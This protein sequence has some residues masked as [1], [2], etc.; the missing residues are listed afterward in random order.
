MSLTTFAA[1]LLIA[2][3]SAQYENVILATADKPSVE[4]LKALNGLSVQE[5]VTRLKSEGYVE[6]VSSS[7]MYLIGPEL[8]QDKL[9]RAVPAFYASISKRETGAFSVAGDEPMLRFVQ[10][11]F[12]DRFD[13]LD[14][15]KFVLGGASQIELTGNGRTVNLKRESVLS[16]DERKAIEE[17]PLA[18]RAPDN[19]VK[20]LPKLDE[21]SP[22]QCDRV[23]LTLV[24]KPEYR[25]FS[26]G[27]DLKEVSSVLDARL[28]ELHGAAT[29]ALHALFERLPAGDL[30]REVGRLER[31]ASFSSLSPA[32]QNALGG[33]I[34]ADFK[35]YGFANEDE[36]ERFLA[37]AKV[38]GVKKGIKLTGAKGKASFISI[39]LFP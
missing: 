22:I 33:H 4:Q 11:A 37:A 35:N 24:G 15:A 26:W 39:A 3:F 27:R 19:P 21:F 7:R 10:A 30:M 36:A 20:D 5:A 6:H 25:Q 1:L 16:A 9:Y 17:S 32:L 28:Q 13:A 38:G 8:M 2:P 18:R 14:Q 31:G 29:S 23:H 12:G 34:V